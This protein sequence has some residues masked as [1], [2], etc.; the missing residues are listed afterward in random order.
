MEIVE[1]MCQITS[2]LQYFMTNSFKIT[3]KT[4][5]CFDAVHKIEEYPGFRTCRTSTKFW[6]IILP[7][8]QLLSPKIK[9]ITCLA[10]TAINR[11]IKK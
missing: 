11:A 7:I 6:T 8:K 5:H 1:S 10:S 9:I 3:S 2:F 4:V